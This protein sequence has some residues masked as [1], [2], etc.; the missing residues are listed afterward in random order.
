[1]KLAPS[2]LAADFTRLGEEIEEIADLIDYIHCDVM[3]GHFVPNLTFGPPVVN[4][5]KD[6]IKLPFDIHLMISDPKAYI[7]RF[8]TGPEDIISFHIEAVEDPRP[9]IA[10]I[11]AL[12]AR[13]GVALSP[14]T[15]ISAIAPILR[16]LDLVLVMAVY[17]GFSGQEFI[18]V[19]P[20]IAELKQQIVREGLK[21]E[22]EVD[23]GLNADNIKEVLSAGA[24]IIV[25]A[26]AIFGQ[27]DRRKAIVELRQVASS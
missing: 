2:I 22:I 17:P 4:A 7:G 21:V 5:L 20:K 3:D 14:P 1:M 25:A 23:G 13:V 15:P 10:E 6:R 16:E 19:L 8:A 26:S 11:R 27:Q 9:V 18:D 24:D 12:R